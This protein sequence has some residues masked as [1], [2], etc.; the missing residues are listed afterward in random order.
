MKHNVAQ[1]AA[2]EPDYLGFIFYD[3]SPRNFTNDDISIDSKIKRV[4]VFVNAP[5]SL[6]IKKI[7]THQL[8]VIQL[9]GD[10]SVFYVNQLN[11]NIYNIPSSFKPK[12]GI[13]LWK[14]FS[15]GETFNFDTT[16]PFENSVDKFLFD[17][18]GK[19]KGGNGFA[20]NW[21]ILKKYPSTKPFILS[22]GISIDNISEIDKLTQ[23]NLPIYAIDVNSK[24]EEQP[25][26]KN[27]K[28][29]EKLITKLTH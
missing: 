8:H 9:H 23:N 26:L 27:I 16:T 22:G 25:G 18:K 14:V 5:I 24:F 28:E 10:E 19:N 6:I 4:G 15:V 29:L 20:F 3:K 17:T 13:E 21:N 2:L 7:K 11:Q 1:V 12:E